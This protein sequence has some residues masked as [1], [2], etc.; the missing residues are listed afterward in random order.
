MEAEWPKTIEHVPDQLFF[1]IPKLDPR[2]EVM[3]ARF[4]GTASYQKLLT[5][6]YRLDRAYAK[7]LGI[8]FVEPENRVYLYISERSEG[9]EH[10]CHYD[11]ARSQYFISNTHPQASN[12][13]RMFSTKKA[14][15][16]W[17]DKMTQLQKRIEQ[18]ETAMRAPIYTE[19]D[20]DAEIIRPKGRKQGVPLNAKL[21]QKMLEI[22]IA[23]NIFPKKTSLSKAAKVI[24]DDLNIMS[25]TYF[26][27][28]PVKQGEIT[29]IGKDVTPSMVSKCLAPTPE[30]RE[31]I[32]EDVTKLIKSS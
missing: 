31:L 18:K 28:A 13:K 11:A 3:F 2:S 19:S 22:R 16:I 27:D 30:V 24:C 25:E 20:C 15:K 8:E 29:P 32:S 10:S 17:H 5:R 7:K 9:N 14:K 21:V 23:K 4:G 6:Q 26:P 1:K 12:L